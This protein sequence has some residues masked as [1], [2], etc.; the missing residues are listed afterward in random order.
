MENIHSGSPST[1]PNLIIGL[2]GNSALFDKEGTM[3]GLNFNLP[4]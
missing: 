4:H 1:Q 2:R 3:I